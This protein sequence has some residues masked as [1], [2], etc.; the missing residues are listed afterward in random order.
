[1]DANNTIKRSNSQISLSD[2]KSQLSL[3]DT[4]YAWPQIG[5]ALRAQ[6]SPEDMKM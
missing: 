2:S 6:E 5:T 3:S 4:G 1:M